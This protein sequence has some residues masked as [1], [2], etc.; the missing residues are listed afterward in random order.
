MPDLNS[1]AA[2]K[3]SFTIS[4]WVK[5]TVLNNNNSILGKGDNF[6][7]KLHEGLLTFTM[8]DIKDYISEASPVP[9]NEWTHVALVHSKLNNELLFFVNGVQTDKIKLIEDYDTSDYNILIGSN[10]WQEF[11]VGYLTNIKIWERELNAFEIAQG[12]P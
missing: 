5:P 2:L 10:L 1:R 12:I 8:A 3:G 4:A 9:L 7:L 11:F 6:V